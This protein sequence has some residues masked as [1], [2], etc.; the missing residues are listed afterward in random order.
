M[1]CSHRSLINYQSFHVQRAIM[2]IKASIVTVII[3]ILGNYCSVNALPDGS[4][5][6]TVG[7]AAVG[8]THLSKG[9]SSGTIDFG[10][11]AITIGNTTLNG[12]TV[13]T[14]TANRNLTVSLTTTNGT[15][16]RGVLIV[17]NSP[18]VDLS[19]RMTLNPN[20]TDYKLQASCAPQKKSGFTHTNNT[21]K[22][23]ANVT[24]I[25]PSNQ[26]AFLDVNIVVRNNNNKTNGKD[27]ESSIYY[28]E[29]FQL[30][31]DNTTGPPAP[32]PSKKTCGI[33]KRSFLCPSGCGIVRRSLGLC[34]K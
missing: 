21:L 5:V 15:E 28:Y 16:F 8:G 22:S 23:T 3:A 24:M 4:P 9:D 33:F 30:M 13:N 12:T 27:E 34:K 25:M 7:K 18:E 14:V 31:S 20:S 26:S 29:R 11:F 2:F 19:N 17:L 1:V 6:C 10:S 32:A